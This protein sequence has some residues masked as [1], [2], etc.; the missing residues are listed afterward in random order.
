M[1]VIKEVNPHFEDFIFDWSKKFYFL[2]GGYGSSKS[3]HIALK[4]ILKLLQEKRTCLVV[5][6]VFETIRESCFSLFFEICNSLDLDDIVNFTKSPMQIIFNNGSKIIFRGLDKPEKLKSIHDISIIWIEECSEI[7]Y[8]GYKEMLGRLRHPSLKLHILLST[9]PVSR[10]NWCYEHF[11]KNPQID[12]VKLYEQRIIKTDDVYYHHS[13]CTD[14]LF[15]T[16]DYFK[17]LDDM[18]YY[19]PDLYRVARLG[20]FGIS[21]RLVLPQFEIKPHH[22]VM[23][24]VEKIPRKFKFCGLDF[25]FEESYNAVVRMAVDD[26]NKWLY[27]YWDY[28]RNHETDD[29]LADHLEDAGFLESRECI[30]CDSAEPK[31][32]RYLKKRGLNA[33]ACKKWNG[34]TIHARR[35]NT[36]KIKRFKRIICSDACKH[37]IKELSELVYEKDRN[38]NILEDEFNIDPHTFSAV[39]YGLDSYDVANLKYRFSKSDFGL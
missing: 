12:D 37:C 10:S 19:D 2:V 30:R 3:Y 9:N 6:E 33:I 27:I 8:A 16:E 15:L 1:E 14:N 5:R 39:W 23:K 24:A 11:F 20:Q 4:V 22:E 17:E 35:D 7:K 18:Q 29:E 28:Y 13:L 38:G 36:R 31:A 21:G 26:E 34:G 25:G 32:I